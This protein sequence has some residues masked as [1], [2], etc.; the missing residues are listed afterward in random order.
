MTGLTAI[1]AITLIAATCVWVELPRAVGQA[2]GVARSAYLAL[3]DPA[4]GDDQK[5]QLAKTFA[6]ALFAESGRLLWRGALALAPA[7]ALL[8]ALH[9]IGAVRAE[10]V[11]ALLARWDLLAVA[12]A[13]LVI[14]WLGW[15]ALRRRRARR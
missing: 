12:G 13:A 11:L 3:L 2:F 9:M 15:R 14:A 6:A 1:L 4:L 10:A 8:G 7:A 5:E